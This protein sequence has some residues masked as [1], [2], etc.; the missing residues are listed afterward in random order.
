MSEYIAIFLVPRNVK[1]CS[2][3]SITRPN[4]KDKEDFDQYTKEG[5]SQLMKQY[6]CNLEGIDGRW[7]PSHVE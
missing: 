1:L 7:E 6:V 4:L 2:V 5:W 3:Q